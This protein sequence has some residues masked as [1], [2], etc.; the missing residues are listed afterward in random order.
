V[1]G[2]LARKGMAMPDERSNEQTGRLRVQLLK[3]KVRQRCRCSCGKGV[4][5]GE[6]RRRWH[7]CPEHWK[8]GGGGHIEGG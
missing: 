2:A 8:I 3:A 5:R 1:G 6:V 4:E 7:K